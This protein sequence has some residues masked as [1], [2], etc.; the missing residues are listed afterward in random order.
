MNYPAFLLPSVST[1]AS[2]FTY[3][4]VT[5]T[6][7]IFVCI[8]W[9][10]LLFQCFTAAWHRLCVRS[11]TPRKLRL[12]LRMATFTLRRYPQFIAKA[13]HCRVFTSLLVSL[14][15]QAVRGINQFVSPALGPTLD[16]SISDE[17]HCRPSLAL[18]LGKRRRQHISNR[19][20]QASWDRY[21]SLKDAFLLWRHWAKWAPEIMW[22]CLSG[23]K[24]G[25]PQTWS[26]MVRSLRV[27]GGAEATYGSHPWLVS[28]L[29]FFFERF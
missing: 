14:H 11:T 25:T 18:V 24:C 22:T 28:G 27:V 29:P 1:S 8:L 7:H 26:P 3:A 21:L 17:E 15:T 2:V 19:W 23:S 4:T 6:L 20:G 9:P 10:C 16:L 12:T 13:T 5:S